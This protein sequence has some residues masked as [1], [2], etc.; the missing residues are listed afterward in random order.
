MSP[1]ILGEEGADF[2]SDIWSVGVTLYEMVTGK[3]PFGG[4]DTPLG[5]M[6]DLIR[7]S[8]P[9]PASEVS[10]GNVPQKLS[11]IIAVALRKEK[12][13]RYKNA[14]EMIDALKRFREKPDDRIEKEIAV[15]QELTSGVSS[16]EKETKLQELVKKYP[17]APSVYQEL[18]LFY[19]GCLRYAEAIA[20]FQKG[21]A[22]NQ[23]HAL[24]HFNLA[25]AYQGRGQSTEAAQNFQKAVDLGL[26]PSFEAYAKARLKGLKGGGK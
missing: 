26:D 3:L 19:N 12:T 20:T 9:K 7:R 6:T 21:L 16:R 1:E 2:R 14:E 10:G 11:E 8:Q 22:F 24:L 23:S 17:K 4:K 5:V 18:G 25:N 15:I 13:D